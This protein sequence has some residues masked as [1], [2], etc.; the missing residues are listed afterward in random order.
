MK[1]FRKSK[2]EAPFLSIPPFP[3]RNLDDFARSDVTATL[4]DTEADALLKHL[5]GARVG[6]TYWGLQPDLGPEPYVL[7]SGHATEL[8][9]HR[10]VRISA[11]GERRSDN[12]QPTVSSDCDPWHLLGNASS[13][14]CEVGDP[15]RLV[16]GILG[17]PVRDAT[18]Q[19]PAM[20]LND[21]ELRELLRSALGPF[22]YRD[23]FTCSA[24]SW[25]E[26]IDLCRTWRGLIDANRSLAGA[27]GFAAWKR[28]TVEPLLWGGSEEQSF[29]PPPHALQRGKQ[30][31]VWRS[32]TAPEQLTALENVGANLVEVEDGFI[33]SAGLGADCVP[34]QSIIIDELGV[35]FDARS[36]SRLECLL[37]EGTFSPE[38]LA[39]AEELR[40]RI[41]VLG[42]SKYDAG[43]VQLDR[44]ADK[45]HVLVP[46]QVEDD[47]AVLSSVGAPLLNLD[48]L[49]RVRL[50]RPNAHI[51]YKPHPDVEAGHR[52]GAI[53][54]EVALELA[55]EVVRA[56][57]I[58]SW[59]DLVDEVHVNSSLAGFEALLRHKRVITHGVPFY[60]GWGLTEDLGPVPARR[61]ARRSLAELV[62]ATLIVYPRYVDPVTNLPCSPEVVIERLSA[63]AGTISPSR[64]LLIRARRA[65]GWL[66][67]NLHLGPV[68]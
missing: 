34:P 59:I 15:L 13:L 56:P 4:S 45:S 58:S 47:R 7:V 22:L 40:D 26:V 36:P 37:E 18:D 43:Q 65:Q 29:D 55:D 17:V 14:V 50:A 63:R 60:A 62:A 8:P 25:F 19:G 33:R 12:Q 64:D 38:L 31:A 5:E 61:A 52:H 2:R 21:G 9:P 57:S 53:S 27:Y 24:I 11:K 51:I 44:R 35:H 42:L 46:G 48:L 32:R 10:C 41:V 3:K 28:A 20:F 6:G 54:D 16:A 30:V 1:A 39:R 49:R 68:R 67:R 66:K 23:P